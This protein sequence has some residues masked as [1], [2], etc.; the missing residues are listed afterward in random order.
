[1][2]VEC[3]L[4]VRRSRLYSNGPF[5]RL[6]L[7]GARPSASLPS[8]NAGNTIWRQRFV[9]VSACRRT[10]PVRSSRCQ[11]VWMITNNPPGRMRVLATDCPHS[12]CFP[13]KAR[14]ASPHNLIPHMFGFVF[15]SPPQ[16]LI[17]DYYQRF[18][19]VD[20]SDRQMESQFG[21][22]INIANCAGRLSCRCRT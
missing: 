16:P 19:S 6:R 14:A 3:P 15:L 13:R 11:R 8:A 20:D 17:S 7:P 4:P 21:K 1:M 22:S 5:Q 9:V 2:C 10:R 18:H 12:H